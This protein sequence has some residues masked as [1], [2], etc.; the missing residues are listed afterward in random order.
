MSQD[1]PHIPQQLLEYRSQK[2][3]E[4]FNNQGEMKTWRA[5]DD[6]FRIVSEIT[7]VKPV[8]LLP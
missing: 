1:Y 2:L 4:A 8:D 5:I 6:L 3:M 7:L